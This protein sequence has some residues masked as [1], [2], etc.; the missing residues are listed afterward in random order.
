MKYTGSQQKKS[1][2][3]ESMRNNM[4][5]IDAAALQSE[6]A[7]KYALPGFSSAVIRK[8]S[9]TVKNQRVRSSIEQN[10][11]TSD[12][13]IIN[14]QQGV[15]SYEDYS[16]DDAEIAQHTFLPMNEAILEDDG[17]LCESCGE[18]SRSRDCCDRCGFF[19]L[20]NIR[21]GISLA[22]HR[23]LV[24]APAKEVPILKG[25][26]D[27]IES[28]LD[29]R[30]D[31]HCPICMVG[32]NQGSE[33]LLSCSHVFHKV[34]LQSFENFMKTPVRCCPICRYSILCLCL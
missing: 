26:W 5:S 29:S 21:R 19:R 15:I 11:P 27:R 20:N 31:A 12:N 28:K 33:V 7:K 2:A 24:A 1:S 3:L 18:E 25:E 23:S 30:L 14:Q 32:F 6:M 16:F 9:T 10:K 13:R 34:C 4:L 22:E 17:F 8:K